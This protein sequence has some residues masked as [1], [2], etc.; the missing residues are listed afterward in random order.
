MNDDPHTSALVGPDG[1]PARRAAARSTNCP[2]C[3]AGEERRVNTAG[4]GDPVICC[5]ECGYEFTREETE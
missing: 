1:R 4:F 5:E 3:G 2:R